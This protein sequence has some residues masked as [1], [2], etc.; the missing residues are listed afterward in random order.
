MRG[1]DSVTAF[2]LFEVLRIQIH[3]VSMELPI[4]PR[5]MYQLQG[6]RELYCS[7]EWTDICITQRNTLDCILTWCHKYT[8]MY[9]KVFV[10]NGECLLSSLGSLDTQWHTD[11][12]LTRPIFDSPKSVNFTWPSDVI[13]KLGVR[14][15][16]YTS[17]HRN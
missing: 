1:K 5:R 10:V 2:D 7:M 17:P 3:V 8:Y 9:T 14:K 13:N 12:Q 4:V 15:V 16:T 6:E 11:L